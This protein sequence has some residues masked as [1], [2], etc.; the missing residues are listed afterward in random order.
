MKR[1][2]AERRNVLCSPTNVRVCLRNVRSSCRRRLRRI[3]DIFV[4]PVS[5]W[6]R[7]EFFEN[8][9]E[10]FA[11]LLCELRWPS[12]RAVRHF[13]HVCFL[14]PTPLNSRLGL[15]KRFDEQF[16]NAAASVHNA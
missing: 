11:S 6:V 12:P 13:I 8:K 5:L 2:R 1:V 9:I 14:F 16:S 7:P 10:V 15:L 3:T 4:T